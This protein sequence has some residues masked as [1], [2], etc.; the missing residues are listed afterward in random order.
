MRCL[1]A[2][3]IDQAKAAVR[4][5]FFH[6]LI[7]LCIS[8][9][10]VWFWWNWE[11]TGERKISLQFGPTCSLR[12]STGRCKQVSH[13]DV[14]QKLAKSKRNKTSGE[15]VNVDEMFEKGIR[16]T[17]SERDWGR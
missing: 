6:F 7:S 5:N 9:R 2:S 12:A 14:A 16:V 11:K 3:C 10:K 17:W 13:L 8:S 15:N 1:L 4:G